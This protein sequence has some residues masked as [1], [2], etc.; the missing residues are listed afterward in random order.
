MPNALMPNLF[1]SLPTIK[2]LSPKSFFLEESLAVIRIAVGLMMAYH[3][4]E[5]FNSKAMAEYATWEVIKKLPFSNYIAYIGKGIEL[6]S[7]I[8]FAIGLCTRIAAIFMAVNMLFICFFIGNG[9]FYYEEQHPFLFAL[10]AIIFIFTGPMKW[11]LDFKFF[12]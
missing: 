2:V 6:V 11:A 7:G 9:R 12:K 4:L 3:G 1:V 5:V 8:L 10:L